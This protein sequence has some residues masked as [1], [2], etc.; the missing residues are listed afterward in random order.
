MK[1]EILLMYKVVFSLSHRFVHLSF[2]GGR[3][4][5]RQFSRINKNLVGSPGKKYPKILQKIQNRF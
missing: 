3:K 2:N 5:Q 1:I 4:G